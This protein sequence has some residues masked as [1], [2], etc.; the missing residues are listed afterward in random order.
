MVFESFFVYVV[1][2]ENILTMKT[3][4]FFITIIL[5]N[6]N[7]ACSNPEPQPTNTNQ[8]TI[9]KESLIEKIIPPK[10]DFPKDR[11][12]IIKRLKEKIKNKQPLV[13]HVFVPLCDNDN[14]GIVP[15]SKTLGDG[16]N[17]RT[18]LYWG[19]LYGVK[20]HFKKK[21]DWKLL[22]A[23][24]D[25]SPNVLERVIFQKKFENGANV[26]LVA[27]AYRGDRMKI[28]LEDYFNSLAGRKNAIQQIDNKETFIYGK[29]DL[30]V[31]NG[32]NGLMDTN[33]DIIYNHDDVAKDAIAVACISF[34]YF[35][36]HLQA[37]KAYPTLMTNHLLAPEAYVLENVFNAWAMLENEEKIHHAAGSAYNQYQK[38]GLKGAKR[39][40]KSGW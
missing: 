28:C 36:K 25:I 26:I 1:M 35:E 2:K 17:L 4:W 14:Q 34:N 29:S 19:A 37:T 12:E 15:V 27:D 22:S 40:Y 24:K 23:E 38:C 32:H 30:L 11:K 7:F 21:K 18:N 39:L 13:I 10:I 20:T 31:F 8:A 3:N 33:V 9:V 16:L 6:F 5:L